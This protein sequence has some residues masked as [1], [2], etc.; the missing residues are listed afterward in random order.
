MH[1][2][3]EDFSAVE[4]PYGDSTFSIVVM[5]PAERKEFSDLIG[6]M[7]ASQWNTCFEASTMRNVQIELPR[8]KYGFKN[9]LNESMIN[10]GLG[11]AFSESADFSRIGTGGGLFISWVIHQTFIDVQEEVFMGIV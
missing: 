8:F 2:V 11:V 1:T 3:T 6:Q 5:L 10:L 7:D 4:L 9:L